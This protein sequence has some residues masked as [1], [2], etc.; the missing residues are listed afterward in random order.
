[1]TNEEAVQNATMDIRM[2]REALSHNS[3]H[4]TE[5]QTR[6]YRNSLRGTNYGRTVYGGSSK[7]KQGDGQEVDDD[8]DDIFDQSGSSENN[9][10][11]ISEGQPPDQ[12]LS[13]PASAPSKQPK[14]AKL[15]NERDLDDHD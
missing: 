3:G 12:R 13:M 7:A 8:D 11:E 4:M 14:S 2:I 5:D 10:D 9:E 15:E 6:S 1:M